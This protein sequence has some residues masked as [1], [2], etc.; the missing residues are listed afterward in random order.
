MGD[1]GFTPEGATALLFSFSAGIAA[2]LV[3]F[4]ADRPHDCG[5]RY[6]PHRK[7]R[8]EEEDDRRFWRL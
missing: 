1:L 2:F 6:C 3:L 7:G 4:I 5:N 8:S